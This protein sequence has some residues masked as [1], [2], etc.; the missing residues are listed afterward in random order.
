M[1]K[2]STI[3]GVC[4]IA[5]FAGLHLS[6]PTYFNSSF[7]STLTD[8]KTISLI[9]LIVSLFTILGL[10]VMHN[11]LTKIGNLRAALALIIIQII[12]FYEFINSG[13]VITSVV[14]FIIWMSIIN[15]ILFTI[16]IFIQKGTDMGHTGRIRGLVM[17]ATNIA[18]ILGPLIGGLLIFEENYRGAY[19]ASFAMLFPILY[20]V[21]K[22]FNNFKD[23]KYIKISA[24]QTILRIM[25]NRDISRI[26]VIN[27]VLQTFYAWM[28]IYIPIYLHNT[29]GFNW[30]EI[31][32]IFTI[33][34]IP[35]AL[36][37]FPLGRLADKKWGEKEI[38]AIG[39]IIL[40]ISTVALFLFTE[41]NL[42][43]L[44]LMLFLTRI[45]AATA[46][47][48]IE[49]YFFK[50]VDDKDPEVLS[51]FRITRPLS[52]FLAPLIVTVGL[53][54][55]TPQYLF[56]VF[57]VICLLTLYPILTIRDTK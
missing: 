6:I 54:Y 33:M 10:L 39:F 23:S 41:K 42:L 17:T 21:Y 15:M 31:S 56:I 53:V 36:V 3:Y 26:F 28:A 20:L 13:S 19:V 18:W 35:F 57:G 51:V 22:N 47:I 4:L 34:L 52:F 49:T 43:D 7:L 16:D 45:G 50:K 55:T 48:M 9:Y 14:L 29:I 24:Y 32:V 11:I 25:K 38:L 44:A 12:I 37:E 27:T 1:K 40:G 30:G 46:E 2:A 8:E 5:F